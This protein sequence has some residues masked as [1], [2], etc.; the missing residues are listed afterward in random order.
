MISGTAT[1]NQHTDGWRAPLGEVRKATVVRARAFR[2]GALPGPVGTQTYWIGSAALRTDGLP[3]LSIVTDPEGLFDYDR[4]IYMLGAVFDQYVAN[5]PGEALTGH[6][7]ANYTQRG[8]AWERTADIECFAPDGSLAWSEP[9]V[10]DI[11]GQSSRSFRQKPFGLKARGETGKENTIEQA[12]FPGLARLGDGAPLV[13]F[14]HLRLRNAGNDWDVAMMR[15]DWCHR[16]VAGLGLDLMSSRAVSLFLDGEYWGVLTLREEQDPQYL[17]E[18]YGL[19]PSEAVILYGQGAIEEG[20]AGDDLVF[21]ALRDYAATH[22]LVVPTH[23]DH[24][25]SRLDLDNCILYQLCE[26]YFANA[27]WPQNNTRV[28]RR[29]LAAP[30]LTQPRGL[31]G[32]WRWLLFDVDLGAGHPWSAGYTENTLAVA[33][34]PTGRAGFDTP[35]ATAFLRALIRN[36]NFKSAFLNTAADLLNSSFLPAHAVALVDAMAAELQPA[37]DEHLRRWRS[38]GGLV[39]TWRER[40]QVLRAFAQNRASQMRQHCIGTLAPGGT[41][42]ITVNVTDPTVDR[43]RV[44]RLTVDAKLPGAGATP[45]PWRGTYFREAPVTFEA[46]PAPGRRFA[47]WTGIET[48]NRVATVNLTTGL[49]VTAHFAAALEDWSGLM[50]TELHYHPAS[51]NGLDDD[52]IE[53]LELQNTGTAVVD[54]TGLVFTQGIA[55]AFTNG[56]TLGP[57][58]YVVLAQDA[59]QLAARFPGIEVHGQYSGRLDN[60]GEGLTLGY[61]GA[62][63]VFELTYDDERPWP[64]LADGGGMSLQ[65]ANALPDFADA[66]NWCAAPPTPGAPVPPACRDGDGDGLPD[67]WELAHALDPANPADAVEDADRDGLDNRQEFQTGTDP[68]DA[69]SALR[70]ERVSLGTEAASVVLAFVARSNVACRVEANSMPGGG[71]WTGIAFVPPLPANRLISVTNRVEAAV[72][73]FRLVVSPQ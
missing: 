56:A 61:P 7:P 19:A 20:R 67:H 31:D 29:R 54:L 37:M 62:S 24:V 55:F 28:W 50:L 41:V 47:G 48:T 49:N 36:P 72:R 70:F 4:G 6:T 8:P 14:R 57:G 43:I 18:H 33:L 45:Y 13:E 5:H 9:V 21:R 53:F 30:D 3:T 23:Y 22:D 35:W 42:Q 71:V 64:V 69:S 15:D 11:K 52:P 25:R 60:A 39:S 1:A 46:I 26:V 12:L 10:L 73:F 32:R 65:R 34:S 40:V 58:A 17:R 68:R 63:T 66:R 38:C 2:P 51:S 59:F 27:D 44:N 16:L